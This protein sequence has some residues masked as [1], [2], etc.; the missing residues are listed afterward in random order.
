[1][2]T[3]DCLGVGFGN[4][5][6]PDI[7]KVHATSFKAVGE[8]QLMKSTTLAWRD[9]LVSNCLS[10]LLELPHPNSSC[11]TSA[12]KREKGWQSLS[13]AQAACLLR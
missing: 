10:V 2:V 3:S 4:D 11:R 8:G 6:L 9:S 12:C 1:M 7:P 5:D 13:N